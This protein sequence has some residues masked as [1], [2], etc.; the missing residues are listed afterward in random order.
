MSAPAVS[1]PVP[2]I[3]EQLAAICRQALTRDERRALTRIE[4]MRSWWMIGSNW[5]LVFPAMALVAYAPNPFTI[6]LA[7][8][9]IGA[10]QLGMGI[11]MHEAAHRTLF[12][13]RQLNDWAG[14]WLAGYPIWSDMYPYRAYHLVHHAQTGT[15]NDPDLSL[16]T[17]FPITKRS[18]ARKL[19]R[20]LSGQTGIKQTRFILQRDLGRRNS[21]SHQLGMSGG[22][23]RD[24]GWRKL[25]P[26]ATT[27]GALLLV[28]TAAGYPAL[29]LLWVVAWLTTYRLL[30]R[31]RSIAEHSM[32]PD[33]SDPLRNTRTIHARWWERLFI[34]PN[35]VNY[36]LEHHLMMS[37]PH[38]NLPR[39]HRLLAERGV[40]EDCCVAE[41][42]LS[43]LRLATSR[44]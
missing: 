6:L 20:D 22:E 5:L 32:V 16:V 17:P 4:P 19:W 42:Y 41:G 8:F 40:L 25:A 44:A 38:H 21:P 9:I 1:T 31:I 11:V 15:P 14:N 30:T 37:V 29:Y 12:R 43:V 33:Q 35:L 27:N 13:N 28:L 2:S 10:R 39:M 24:G 34:A 26:I 7:L 18:F 23:R 3:S 36:H